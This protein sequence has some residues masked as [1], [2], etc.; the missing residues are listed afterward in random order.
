M[1]PVTR[2]GWFAG[3]GAQLLDWRRVVARA[4]PGV[5]AL[6]RPPELV[7]AVG[8]ARR[9]IPHRELRVVETHGEYTTRGER[10]RDGWAE[11]CC[12]GVVV[13]ER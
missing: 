9:S 1:R 11:R 10:R 5:N 6:P 3:G 2:G 12:G 13:A 7:D 4:R 8:E